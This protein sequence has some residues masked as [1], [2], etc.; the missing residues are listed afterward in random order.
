MSDAS[1]VSPPVFAPAR[2]FWLSGDGRV[3][4]AAAG[5]VITAQQKPEWT[6][7]KAFRR[8]AL[9]TPWP[10]DIDGAQTAAALNDVL[11]VH[12]LPALTEH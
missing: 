9:P 7:Y 6:A 5:A 8:A 3:Y 10:R 1:F 2:W 4:S 12:G 11:A